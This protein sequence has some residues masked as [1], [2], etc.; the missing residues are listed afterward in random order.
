[1][2]DMLYIN[3][4][5][6]DLSDGVDIT[7]NYKSNML[8]D[9]SKIVG[10]NSYTIKLP[11]TSRNLRIIGGAD[12]PSVVSS[13]PRVSH[14]ARY[15]RN[16]VEI[17]PDGRAVLLSVGESI[18]IA[19]TWGN[20]S[21]LFKL[22]EDGKNLTEIEGVEDY[23]SW[24]SSVTASTY[25]GTDEVLF[26]SIWLYLH[27]TNP[28]AALHPSVRSSYIFNLLKLEYGLSVEFPEESKEFIN[29]LIFPL[30][31]RNGG[32]V[33]RMNNQGYYILSDLS[34]GNAVSKGGDD[35]DS[36]FEVETSGTSLGVVSIRVKVDC[37]VKITPSFK[38]MFIGAALGY[39]TDSVLENT[40]YLH[41]TAMTD[42]GIT[43]YHYTEPVEV[44]L[45]A[46]DRFRISSIYPTATGIG[47]IMYNFGAQPKEIQL[48]D[49]F[50]IAENLPD[51]KIV[52]FI[53]SVASMAGLFAVP[54][55]DGNTIQF[56]SFDSLGDRGKALDW[57]DKLIPRD[58]T[59][60]PLNIGYTLPDFAKNNRMKYAEDD[61]V[62][63][64]ADGNIIVGDDTLDYERDAV[65]LPFAPSDSM[66]GQ[67]EIKLY[68]YNDEGIPELQDVEPRVLR[69]IN[70]G[71]Y[72]TGTFDGL[73][74]STL[75]A[76]NYS[77]YQNA[78]KSPV[79]ITERILLDELSLRDLDMSKPVY[80]RQY[81]KYY[82]IVEVKAPSDG[83]CECKLLQ[84]ED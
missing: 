30:V 64:W 53:K 31:T 24:D 19:L 29:S 26:S 76:N 66:M 2:R 49:K 20:T 51:I 6:V 46:G 38:S 63:T 11:K 77:T 15:F 67:A 70:V 41:Y 79:V 58:H 40:V 35:F 1:M 60:A 22:V 73:H 74:W 52:D 71:G 83:V 57:S 36:V 27:T 3:G 34:G 14:P 61:T 54:S 7:L 39:G 23:V 5:L 56:V 32:Y 42:M 68:E 10:N 37:H 25:N 33:N 45:S 59:N 18:E 82:A 13:F 78:V 43:Y 69:E 81:G 17:V 47:G 84:L 4:E 12:V 55:K 16:G 44:D 65:E 48:G 72:S 28:G 8:T 62:A 80:L 50:P 21:A 9:L 75:I